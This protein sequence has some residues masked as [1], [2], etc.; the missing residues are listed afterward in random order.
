MVW[1][2]HFVVVHPLWWGGLP[3]KLKGVFDRILLPGMAFRY[4][5]GKTPAGKSCLRG[6]RQ[7]CW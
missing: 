1:C 3:A 7:R 5:S 4:V 2:E 6:A